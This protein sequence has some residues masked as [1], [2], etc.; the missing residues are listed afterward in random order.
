MF[1]F[2]CSSAELF[3]IPF[4]VFGYIGFSQPHFL[5]PLRFRAS[6]HF[7]LFRVHDSIY[8]R[9]YYTCIQTNTKYHKDTLY[10]FYSDTHE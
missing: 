6:I 4:R 3:F 8:F 10:I 9:D 1:R 5:L 2:Y 7:F